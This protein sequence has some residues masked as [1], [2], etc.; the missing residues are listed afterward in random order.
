MSQY[1][2]ADRWRHNIPATDRPRIIRA[3]LSAAAIL[4][5]IFAVLGMAA[6]M[7]HGALPQRDVVIF[8]APGCG[9][10]E[11]LKSVVHTGSFLGTGVNVIVTERGDPLYDEFCA[12]VEQSPYDIEPGRVGPV[13]KRPRSVLL[14]A[15]WVRGSANYW[16]GYRPDLLS[17]LQQ[18]LVNEVAA[19]PQPSQKWVPVQQP[20][21]TPA[22]PAQPSPA[23]SPIE[24]D[25]DGVYVIVTIANLSSQM[26]EFRADVARRADRALSE[27]VRQTV[28]DKVAANI[29][30]EVADPD[31]FNAVCRS[32]GVRPGANGIPVAC[33]VLIPERF[34]GFQALIVKRVELALNQHFL[35]PLQ[36]AGISV[37]IERIHGETYGAV[38]EAAQG[39]GDGT[40]SPLSPEHSIP[41]ALSAW[42]AERSNLARRLLMMFGF[43]KD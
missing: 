6:T 23:P 27:L 28:G 42:L 43:V 30:A 41:F 12:T 11:Q 25:F 24:P 37:V 33:H 8:T 1:T 21:L 5:I 17:Q 14:P 34:K 3:F 26:T 29:I 40:P 15:V 19:L 9:P 18:F 32:S 2:T 39:N 22:A 35:V 31:R 4:F 7:A 20:R 10:C 36:S 13:G 16:I 38:L